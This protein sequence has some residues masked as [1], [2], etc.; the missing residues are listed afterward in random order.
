LEDSELEEPEAQADSLGVE[1]KKKKGIGGF[2][3]K[4]KK[5]KDKD[6]DTNEEDQPPPDNNN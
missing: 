5:K 2:L 1:P 3:N 6:P 4:F